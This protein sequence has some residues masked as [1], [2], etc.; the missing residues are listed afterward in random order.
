MKRRMTLQEKL[1]RCLCDKRDL[2]RKAPKIRKC[3]KEV[4]ELLNKGCSPCCK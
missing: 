2:D 1:S 4:E 3:L